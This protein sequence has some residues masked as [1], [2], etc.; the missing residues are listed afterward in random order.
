MLWAGQIAELYRAF[1][2]GGEDAKDEPDAADFY[3]GEM[4]MRRHAGGR[5]EVYRGQVERAILTLYLLRGSHPAASSPGWRLHHC[6][7]TGPRLLQGRRM[8][9]GPGRPLGGCY[10]EACLATSPDALMTMTQQPDVTLR[11]LR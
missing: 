8:A 1:R 2:K 6:A 11:T 10:I 9:P 4:E 3:Y 7:R 5:G